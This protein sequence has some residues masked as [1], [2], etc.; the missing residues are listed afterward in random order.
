MLDC[1]LRVATLKS[2]KRMSSTPDQI[3]HVYQYMNEWISSHIVVEL[4]NM[5]NSF[6]KI[7]KFVMRRRFE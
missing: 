1:K 4:N 5:E 3:L 6:D 7:G 2:P